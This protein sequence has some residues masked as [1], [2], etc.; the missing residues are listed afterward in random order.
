MGGLT[1]DVATFAANLAYDAIPGSIIGAVKNGLTDYAAVTVPGQSADVVDLMESFGEIDGP[2]A[3]ANLF[4][5]A[6]RASARAAALL[7]GA[8][9]HAHDYDEVGL[10]FH[11][12]HPSVALAPAIFAEPEALGRSG[13]DVLTAYVAGYEVWGEIGSRDAPPQHLKGWHPTG[14]SGAV[15]AAAAC[16]N[17]RRLDPVRTANALAIAAS[18]ASGIAGDFDTMTKPFHAGHAAQAGL[19]AARYAQA[20]MTASQ[21]ILE[22]KTGFQRA[23]SPGGDVDVDSPTRFHQRWFSLDHGIGVKLY[24]MCYGT[25]RLISRLTQYAIENDFSAPQIE[26]VRWHTGSSRALEDCADVRQYVWATV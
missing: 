5:L 6:R 9:G 4:L 23:V 11:P 18:Q 14:T 17:L 25:H 20:G 13:K 22:Y 1:V 3:E 16:A 21:E 12:A 10:S 26:H 24:P 8:S 2:A 7:N 15:A 19:T